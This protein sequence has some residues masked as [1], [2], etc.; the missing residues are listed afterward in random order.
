MRLIRPIDE[1]EKLRQESGNV[2]V[3][4]PQVLGVVEEL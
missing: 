1:L 2:H 4:I 3:T